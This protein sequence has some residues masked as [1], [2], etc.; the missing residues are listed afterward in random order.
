MISRQ[1]SEEI[2]DLNPLLRRLWDSAKPGDQERADGLLEE[3]QRKE[4]SNE[5]ADPPKGAHK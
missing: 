1:V 4:R 5:P 2:G 3:A